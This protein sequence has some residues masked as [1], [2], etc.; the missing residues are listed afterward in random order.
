MPIGLSL[1]EDDV[2]AV[3]SA[4]NIADEAVVV[5]DGGAKNIKGVPVKI[6][7]SGNITEV[8]TEAYK[9]G[10]ANPAHSEGLTFYDNTK[11]AISYYNEEADVVVNLGQEVLIP[12][13]NNTGLDIANGA[14]VYPSGV[15][16]GSGLVTID[17]ADASIKA[18][19][20][21]VGVATHLIED[22]T[23]GYVTRLGSV[24]GLNTAGLSGILYLSETVPGGFTMTAPTDGGYVT[25]IGAVGV[26]DG[27]NGTIIVD[28]TTSHIT[29]EVTDTNGFPSD[30]R[31][32]TTI[33]FDDGTLTFSITPTGTAFHYYL[34]GDKY[35]ITGAETKAI[36]DVTGIHAFYYDNSTLSTIANPTTAQIDIL[37]RT[38]A[39][40][41][42]VY[43]NSTDAAHYYLGDERHGIIMDPSTHAR[44]HFVDG[45][46]FL[47]GL[48]LNSIVIGA[49]GDNSHAQ[50][51]SD[52]GYIAD[53]DIVTGLD[54]V[55]STTG[56]KI[57][58]R[59]GAS[60]EW[61]RTTNAGYPILVGATPLAQYNEWT[62]ATWQLTEATS[63]LIVV[64]H[65]FA[66][67]DIL[68][69]PWVVVGLDEY[70]NVASATAGANDE[71]N[72]IMGT[73]ANE[74]Y[75]PI[76]SVLFQTK[77]SYGNIVQTRIVQDDN[78][79]D[80]IDWRFQD[81]TSGGGVSS[82]NNLSSLEL[83]QS[84]VTW[85]HIDD[86]AQTIAGL[87]TFTDNIITPIVIGGTAASGT[88]TL[89]SSSDATKGKILFGV[90][91]ASAYDETNDRWGFGT[92][93]PNTRLDLLV[94]T[95]SENGLNIK[96]SGAAG[97]S[98]RLVS[99][100]GDDGQLQL[101]ESTGT[102]R[103]LLVGDGTTDSYINAGNF[104]VGTTSPSYKHEVN[105]TSHVNGVFTATTKTFKI[106]HPLVPTQKILIHA[107]FEGPEHG[108]IYR[109]KTK[110]VNGKAVVKIDEFFGMTPGTFMALCQDVMIQSL[111]N[112]DSY[113]KLIPGK[114]DG[115]SFEVIC[116]NAN[117]NDEFSWLITGARKDAAVK[118]SD[119][120]TDDG[121]L[122]LETDKEEPTKEEL[123]VLNDIEVATE[124]IV[125]DK[126]V[127]V[128]RI[129]SL[130][131]KRGYYMNPEAFGTERPKKNKV[132]KY[133]NK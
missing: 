76:A 94:G 66:T 110:L 18:K 23:R 84:G 28:P 15:D 121:R 59:S 70:A 14:V 34:L 39:L 35:E 124:D 103:V 112:Q 9:T 51:G 125:K 89:Q 3:K 96:S 128:V 90:A 20:R 101:I 99:N 24:G 107:V 45:A 91:G 43:W 26:A 13:Y 4:A 74:E 102:G 117:S 123:E 115:D 58:Y 27:T 21:L 29:V 1:G 120:N 60:G 61:K 62:G 82:H 106:D 114:I 92:A 71:I 127:A 41:A 105:G 79:N 50:F 30:Q 126:T 67:N 80:Y 63:G 93:S 81:I 11:K 65:V 130:S 75:V 64:Y 40:V 47:S 131:E 6:D 22:G 113:D 17:L 98:A 122:I 56:F 7:T 36:T 88:L 5:G 95:G 37:I 129:D 44:L 57:F 77:T 69:E 68:D 54:A 118:W 16:V 2:D 31:S 133:K 83:A 38:K 52:A 19:C 48:A 10:E 116:E 73:L 85:G 97:N 104:G 78:G 8:L 87:K 111:Q 53:E 86:Q 25:A 119:Q 108:L 72:T 33:A 132:F 100:A 42:Y 32:G 55:V 109:G 12:V 49:G 46:K